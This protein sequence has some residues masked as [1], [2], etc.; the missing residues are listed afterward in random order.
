MAHFGAAEIKAVAEGLDRSSA[1]MSGFYPHLNR[2][3]SDMFLVYLFNFLAN[4]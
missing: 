4:H 3:F 1:M 2:I